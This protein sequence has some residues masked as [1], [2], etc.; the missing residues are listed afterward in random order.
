[1]GFSNILVF[2]AGEINFLH[3]HA[4]MVVVSI[5]SA[6][7]WASLPITLAL[8]GAIITTSAF[9]AMDTCSTWNWK[10]RSK[11]STRH[12][13]PVSVSKVMG[14]IK[15]VAF[16]VISTWTSACC[17]FN[18]LARYAILYAAILPVTPRSTVF[19][20]NIIFPHLSLK[21]FG[22]NSSVILYLLSVPLI[23]MQRDVWMQCIFYMFS[24]SYIIY[25]Y[26]HLFFVLLS[27]IIAL[28]F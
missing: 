18:A 10:F 11:V 8:A 7:P 1:M 28:D 15:L 27:V 24:F 17:F 12:L 19:P 14:L 9:F 20:S 3:L 5:S 22:Q 2:I 21:S 13:F 25:L 4:I 26:M 16:L 6:I 23:I